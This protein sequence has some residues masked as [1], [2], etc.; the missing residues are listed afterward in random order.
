MEIL[1]PMKFV[2]SRLGL[3]ITGLLFSALAC[4]QAA[5]EDSNIP[6]APVSTPALSPV[7]PTPSTPAEPGK[8]PSQAQLPDFLTEEDLA[9][10]TPSGPPPGVD[11]GK[12][13][14]PIE[15]VV[16][17]TFDGGSLRLS[18]AS[19]GDIERLRDRIAP[20]YEP[21]YVAADGGDWL[22]EDDLVLGYES[23]TE[24]AFA[25][26]FRILNFHEIVNDVIDGTPILISYCPLC[27]SAIVYSR[28]TQ[29]DALLF[30]NT[31]ALYESDLVMYD[32]QTGSYWFQVLGEAIVGP[33]T[34]ARLEV[35]PSTTTT[36]GQWRELHPDTKVLSR[37]LG[38]LRGSAFGSPYDRDPFAGYSDAVNSG[39]FAFPVDPDKLDDRLRPGD[40]VITINV[41]DAHRAYL[42]TGQP[43]K[44]VNDEVNGEKV[45]V[46]IRSEGPTASAF[47]SALDGRTLVFELEGGA[48]RD[49]ETGSEWNEGGRAVAGRL[50]GSQLEAVPS[51]ASFWF[52]IVGALPGLEVHE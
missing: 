29:S 52:S 18:E 43:D 13:S 26:P 32:H 25:Y 34:G 28:V 37:D 9:L 14:V 46:F 20:I 2:R 19:E 42:L 27:A 1:L 7:S 45:V 49:D 48:I 24:G 36:W 3:A 22:D 15:E 12:S 17:D 11:K 40:R 10:R 41:G 47:F 39:R 30:G 33:L 38:L 51:R 44:V 16:F 5:V 35:F 6:P 50:A 23:K 4:S 8:P 31:S 21:R